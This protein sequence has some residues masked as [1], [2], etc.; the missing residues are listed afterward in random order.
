M[1]GSSVI[2]RNAAITMENVFVYA[3]GLNNLPSC[4]S[5]VSTGRK[6]TAMTSSAKKLGPPTSLTAS[7]TTR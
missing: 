4:A 7:I 1:A 6:A 2:A 3:S 5:N